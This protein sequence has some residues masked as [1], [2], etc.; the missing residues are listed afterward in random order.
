MLCTIP[1]RFWCDFLHR[2]LVTYHDAVFHMGLVR[3]LHV[4]T[5]KVRAGESPSR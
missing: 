1:E 4:K 5:T 3:V 2:A